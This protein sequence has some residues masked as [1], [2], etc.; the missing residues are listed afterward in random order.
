MVTAMKNIDNKF[1]TY[2]SLAVV[3]MLCASL[4]FTLMRVFTQ[5][6]LLEVKNID[7][8]FV[9]TVLFDK[10]ISPRS[11][12]PQNYG[13]EGGDDTLDFAPSP[14]VAVQNGAGNSIHRFDNRVTGFKDKVIGS[15]KGSLTWREHIIEKYNYFQSLFGWKILPQNKFLLED[16]YV[17]AV[18]PAVDPTPFVESLTELKHHLDEL[19]IS[20]LYV[21]AP[22]K[23]DR[24]SSWPGEYDY[25]HENADNFTAGLDTAGINYLD[26]RLAIEANGWESA[27][28]FYKTDHH[29]TQK[30]ALWAVS[31]TAVAL[32]L[33]HGFNIDLGLYDLDKYE[34][35]IFPGIFLG[36][37]GRAV[38]RAYCDPEDFSMLHPNFYTQLS[39]QIPKKSIDVLG[40]F[41]VTYNYDSIDTETDIYKRPCYSAFAYDDNPLTI[42]HNKLNTS[43]ERVLVIKDSFA[44]PFVQFLALGVEYTD[45]I[46]LRQYTSSLMGYIEDT[47]P[48]T[49]IF[50][51]SALSLASEATADFFRFK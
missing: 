32:N 7:N 26:L 10:K 30:T 33:R 47:C 41:D 1:S 14:V 9:Q 22:T 2:L 12:T 42:F 36:S 29:W 18:D 13:N 43:G 6:Y 45:V 40:T 4:P 28:L 19:G 34:E 11:G 38:T 5:K 39:L 49:V 37:Y 8:A 27:S 50:V 16:G 48:D 24:G 31:E 46:D 20:M 35:E 17:T 44:C 25:I 23:N 21:Q 51:Y 15:L 3:V